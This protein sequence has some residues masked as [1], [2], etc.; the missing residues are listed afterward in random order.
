MKSK[1][2]CILKWATFIVMVIFI[3]FIVTL[4]GDLLLTGGLENGEL[5]E[6]QET[7]MIN[8][9]GVLLGIGLIALV[10]NFKYIW[11]SIYEDLLKC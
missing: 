1:I 3:I 8:I 10:V 6:W 5:R 9:F 2:N 7:S 11:S 4:F